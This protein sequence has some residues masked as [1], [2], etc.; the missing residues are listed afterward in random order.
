MQHREATSSAS[1]EAADRDEQS[2]LETVLD[3]VLARLGTAGRDVVVLRFFGGNSFAD[4]GRLLGISEEAAKKRVSR[5][6]ARLRKLL[7]RHGITLG[8]EGLVSALGA[9]AINPA[10][11]GLAAKAS[12]AAV[13][14]VSLSVAK[15]LTIMAWTKAKTAAVAAATLLLIGGGA[16]V[17]WHMYGGSA[18]RMTIVLQPG[19]ITPATQFTWQDPLQP[20]GDKTYHGPPIVGVVRTAD[21]K[22]VAGATVMLSTW[23]NDVILHATRRAKRAPT[24]ETGPD[25][26]FEFRPKSVPYGVLATCNQGIGVTTTAKLAAS[27]GLVIEPWGRIDGTAHLGPKPLSKSEVVLWYPD[28]T[29]RDA[30]RVYYS[31]GIPTTVL[32]DESGHFVF[33]QV[34]PGLVDVTCR[35][36]GTL[37]AQH[38]P[39]FHVQSG[40]TTYIVAGGTGRPIIGLV[41]PMPR[42]GNEHIVRLERLR[43]EPFQSQNWD[44]LTAEGRAQLFAKMKASPEFPAWERD[45]NLFETS[46]ASD[47]SFRLD[48]VP[49]GRYAMRVGYWSIPR[50]S[51]YIETI[52]DL[53]RTLTVAAMPG[54]RSDEP[55]DLGTIDLPLRKRLMPGDPAPGLN[56]HDTDGKATALQSLGGKYVLGI[57]LRNA[58]TS[59][60]M[61][62]DLLKLKPL[63]D[64]FGAD[65][66]LVMLGLYAGEGFDAARQS[67]AH[68]GVAWPLVNPTFALRRLHRRS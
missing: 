55:L 48:D 2:R 41:N 62:E 29:E 64:R 44:Q 28:S 54:G 67:A 6:L 68:A 14:G 61:W 38:S 43:P 53:Q 30:A 10:P 23:D 8:P 17:G 32:T 18:G 56:W 40:A 58:N 19:Q 20:D 1:Q 51:R 11:A 57:V 13:A 45:C 39:R 37:Q 63:Y 21:G 36:P 25:G 26:R 46:I 65:P 52:G 47:G 42:E 3:A 24:S 66:R 31:G 60:D 9:V 16:S 15:G 27:A 50:A 59:D 12:H 7:R 35:L 4:V 22:P 5:S 34:P 33:S 49:A